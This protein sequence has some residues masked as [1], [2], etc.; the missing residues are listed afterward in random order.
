MQYASL[1]DDPER[2]KEVHGNPDDWALIGP[3]DQEIVARL[4]ER[5]MLRLGSQG[6]A[7]TLGWRWGYMYTITPSTKQ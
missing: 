3:F 6:G 5:E 4:W 2:Q 7:G 1:T